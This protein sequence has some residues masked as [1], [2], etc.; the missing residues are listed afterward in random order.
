MSISGRLPAFVFD[1]FRM[2][3]NSRLSIRLSNDPKT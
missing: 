1:L 3:V 2:E